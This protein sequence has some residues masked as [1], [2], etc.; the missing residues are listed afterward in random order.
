MVSIREQILLD[1]ILRGMEQETV[2]RVKAIKITIPK[3]DVWEYV[4]AEIADAPS[5]LPDGAYV[6]RFDGRSMKVE[7]NAGEWIAAQV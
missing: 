1:G 6:V 2:C 5:E 7:K 4:R 3:L